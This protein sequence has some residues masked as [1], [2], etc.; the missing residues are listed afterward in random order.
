MKP[1]TIFIRLEECFHILFLR[2]ANSNSKKCIC[3]ESW[4]Q[5]FVL[6][7]SAHTYNMEGK[8]ATRRGSFFYIDLSFARAEWPDSEFQ[9]SSLPDYSI[10]AVECDWNSNIYQIRTK[11][12]E[13]KVCFFWKQT[14]IFSK[15]MK[16]AS[17]LYQ[18]NPFFNNVFATLCMN[19]FCKKIKKFSYWKN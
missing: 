4:N 15:S 18:M 12:E 10:F 17:L 11:V 8:S 5:I 16:V 2:S 3:C 7:F 19:I 14:G 13:K 9:D 6:I 1:W